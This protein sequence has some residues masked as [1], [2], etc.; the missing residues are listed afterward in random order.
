MLVFKEHQGDKCIIGDYVFPQS[1]LN[2]LYLAV[3]CNTVY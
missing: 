2:S 1:S 3:F